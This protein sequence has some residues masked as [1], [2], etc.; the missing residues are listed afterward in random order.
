MNEFASVKENLEKVYDR[1]RS[2]AKRAGRD[3]DS[4]TLVAVT[5]TF[6]PEA[7]LAAYEAG[8]RVF[9]ENYVQE[10]RRK[11]EAVG[12]SDISWH[13]IG[14]LQTN[15]AKYAVKLFDLVETVDS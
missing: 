5:K 10:A 8:Q 14:H 4:I 9:G 7:V 3:P 1:I 15:K 2:A 6:G 13:M 12:K 11:I